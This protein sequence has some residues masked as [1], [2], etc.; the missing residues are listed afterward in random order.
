LVRLEGGAVHALGR[1]RVEDVGDRRDA[2]LDRDLVARESLRVARSVD[3]LVVRE[4]HQR[5]QVEQLRVRAT[6]DAVTNLRVRL[7]HQPLLVAE[8]SRLEQDPVGDADLADVVHRARD[9]DQLGMLGVDAGQACEQGAVEAHPDDVL[10]GF[11]IAELGRPRE[12]ANR[13]FVQPPRL[14]LRRLEPRDRVAQRRGALEH[15]LLEPVAVVA[16]LDLERAPPQRVDDIDQQFVRLERLQH[17]PVCPLR[18]RGLGY[19][20]VVEPGD[21]DD[22]GV[23]VLE[24]HLLC[25]VEARLARHVDVAQDERERLGREEPPRD[26]GTLGGGALVAV[27]AEQA[28]E[29]G[30]DRLLVVDDQDALGFRKE[31]HHAV[32]RPQRRTIKRVEQSISESARE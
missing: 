17:V 18:E 7:H 13:L 19:A 14:A 10:T 2:P 8:R 16:V 12:P 6:Q 24:M 5:G 22:R 9:P 1:E 32:Y 28:G 20:A 25:E 3:P 31:M 21:E 30:A 15:R 11:V 29:Q 23:W 4:R 27:R 26:C